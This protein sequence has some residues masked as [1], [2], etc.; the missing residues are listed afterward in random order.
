MTLSSPYYMIFLSGVI[1]LYYL[2]GTRSRWII[3][4]SAS[5]FFYASWKPE[6]LFV[7]AGT[8]A[9]NYFAAVAM[10]GRE[11]KKSRRKYLAV[12]L[13]GG[14]GLLFFFKYFDFFSAS[15]QEALKGWDLSFQSPLLN[16]VMP[17]GLSFYTL[18]TIGYILDVYHGRVNPE[19]HF[20]TFAV[21]VS[22]FPVVL[23]GPIEHSRHLLPQLRRENRIVF[24]YENIS[25]GAKL[26]IFGLFYKLVVADRAAIYVNAV[27]SNASKHSG[28]T[29][30]AAVIFF[31]FQ[32]YGDFAG[33]SYIAIG[34]AKML[35]IDILQNFHRPY[36]AGSI[37]EFWRRWHIS[38]STWLRDYVFLPVAY[39]LSRRLKRERYLSVRTDR[40][41]YVGAILITFSL[42]G[43]WHGANWTYIVWG[44]LHGFYL[45]AENLLGLKT[46]RRLLNVG[47]TYLLILFT[48]IF[49]R[50]ASL[51]EAVAIIGK[52]FTRP[53]KLFIPQG[54][55]IVAP[56]YAVLA[57]AILVM[58]ESKQEFLPARF[59]LFNNERETVRVLSYAAVIVLILTLG[60]FNGGQFIYAQF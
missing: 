33:Y 31:S 25:R 20:G 38:L 58:M 52:I 46:R 42:C 9:V 50:A 37:K 4:L 22:F 11:D 19:R 15:L 51:S 57:I 29:F 44:C 7:L 26:I 14:L 39:S 60:V 32:I 41:V 5:Y 36:F 40:I 6:Y 13:V 10:G 18:Q 35:G 3:L 43:L 34:S 56:I 2:A 30:V 48:W 16:L 8:T 24:S 27:F 55:D 54:A 47:I 59:S 1:F 12:S 53:G 17:I 49:F 21:Y 28:L 45:A 23:S